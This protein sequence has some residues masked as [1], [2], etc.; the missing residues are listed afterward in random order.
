[1]ITVK[2]KVRVTVPVSITFV[3]VF[4]RAS[5]VLVAGMLEPSY[6]TMFASRLSSAP[7]SY[8]SYPNDSNDP[9]TLSVTT[10]AHFVEPRTTTTKSTAP[11]T[12]M[13]TLTLEPVT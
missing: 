9:V 1:M 8:T 12:P 7:A 5:F 11:S 6:K 3:K 2:V 13:R 10:P 4:E